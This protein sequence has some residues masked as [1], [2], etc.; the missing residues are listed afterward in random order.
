MSLLS[1]KNISFLFLLIIVLISLG[2][3]WGYDYYEPLYIYDDY[4]DIYIDIPIDPHE[5]LPVG[6]ELN[7]EIIDEDLIASHIDTYYIYGQDGQF[8]G[9][10]NDD[11]YDSTSVCDIYGPYGSDYSYTSIFYFYG[12][13][14]SEYSEYS[15]FDDFADFPPILYED[16]FAIAYVTTNDLFLPRV[17]PYYLMDVLNNLG[18]YVSR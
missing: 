7:E 6:F 5:N 12:R 9:Y 16:D 2:A 14:G 11:F 18:C 3:C 8:L 4:D 15:A 1:I 17:D 13:Y 10:V